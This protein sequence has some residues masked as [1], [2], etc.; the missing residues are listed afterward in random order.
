LQEE[1]K[2]S[3]SKEDLEYVFKHI[4]LKS[5]SDSLISHYEERL[6]ETLGDDYYKFAIDLLDEMC[7]GEKM[8]VA[9]ANTLNLK[10]SI[11]T[12]Y[13]LNVLTHDGYLTEQDN[14][15]FFE[16]SLLRQWWQKRKQ[17]RVK[18]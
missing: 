5:E 15:W 18:S 2:E 16:K 7:G 4:I 13:I 8:N 3:A 10:S 1:G 11:D 12:Q 17:F 9:K 6:N 14:C